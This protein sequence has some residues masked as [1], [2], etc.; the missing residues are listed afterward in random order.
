ME[1]NR[2]SYRLVAV[3]KKLVGLV[4]GAALAAVAAGAAYVVL[5]GDDEDTRRAGALTR[6]YTSGIIGVEIDGVGV[7]VVKSVSGCDVTAPVVLASTG[8]GTLDKRSG[9]PKYT[10]CTLQFGS[11]LRAPMYQWISDSLA[12]KGVPRNVS[13]VVFDANYK[14]LRRLDLAGALISRF[15]IPGLASAT[16]DPVI[17]ELTLSTETVTRANPSGTALTTSKAKQL[18]TGYFRVTAPGLETDL[19]KVTAVD[20]WSFDI[21]VAQT[22]E[23]KTAAT[24]RPAIGDLSVTISGLT[25][26]FDAWLDALVKGAPTEKPMTL[27]LTDPATT[28]PLVDVSFTAT[29]LIGADLLGSSESSANAKRTFSMYGEGA[30]IKFNAGVAG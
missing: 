29:G 12:G 1:A 20:S 27:S 25:P 17:F 24:G 30:T 22:G 5:G 3:N 16:T 9:E 10:P 23:F 6:S 14:P 18:L 7:G 4:A 26:E 19:K 8:D 28:M 2:P 13:I 15:V 21:P 11:G